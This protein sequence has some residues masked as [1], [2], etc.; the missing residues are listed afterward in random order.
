M[1]VSK[2]LVIIAV[3]LFAIAAISDRAGFNSP[4]NLVAGGLFFWALATVV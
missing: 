1:S 4:V 3:V 2:I